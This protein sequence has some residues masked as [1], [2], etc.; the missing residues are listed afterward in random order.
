MEIWPLNNVS[1]E[2]AKTEIRCTYTKPQNKYY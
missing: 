1:K 2:V